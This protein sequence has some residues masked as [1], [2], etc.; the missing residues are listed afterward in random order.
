MSDLG[1]TL[2][3]ATRGMLTIRGATPEED[4]AQKLWATHVVDMAD[5][6]TL[7]LHPSTGETELQNAR[8]MLAETVQVYERLKRLYPVEY[9]R[10]GCTTWQDFVLWCR[11]NPE[12]SPT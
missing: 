5:W 2:V 10:L 7:W 3:A 9:A 4:A 8:P 12:P 6:L 1:Q 11:A